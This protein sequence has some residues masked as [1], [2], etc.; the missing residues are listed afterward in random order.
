MSN[1]ILPASTGFRA[2]DALLKL[3]IPPPPYS[4]LCCTSI[5]DV[6]GF[7]YNKAKFNY[8]QLVK[9]TRADIITIEA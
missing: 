4:C 1:H 2:G 5:V 7:H 6:I 8:S 9:S 3:L